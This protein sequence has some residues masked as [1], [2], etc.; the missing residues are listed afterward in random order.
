MTKSSICSVAYRFKDLR[1]KLTARR[2]QE[3]KLQPTSCCWYIASD[4]YLDLLQKGSTKQRCTELKETTTN[5][6]TIYSHMKTY[7]FHSHPS[8][9]SSHPPWK[10]QRMQG[11]TNNVSICRRTEP[12]HTWQHCILP[13]ASFAADRDRSTGGTSYETRHTWT[14]GH[15]KKVLPPSSRQKSKS[16]PVGTHTAPILVLTP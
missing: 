2:P 8:T 4:M 3:L 13:R 15:R 9:F 12:S 5:I 7:I 1:V 10:N 16:E 11:G 14:W 6:I